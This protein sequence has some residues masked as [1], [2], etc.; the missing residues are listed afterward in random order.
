MTTTHVMKGVNPF[1]GYAQTKQAGNLKDG[2]TGSFTDAFSKATG[3]QNMTLQKDAG[4]KPGTQAKPSNTET[5]NLE[6]NKA[7]KIKDNG[8]EN[9]SKGKDVQTV[10]KVQ[11]EAEKAGQELAGEVAEEL[12]VTEEEVL[13]AMELLGLTFSDLLNPD[14]MTQL[15]LTV[16]EAD[17]LTLMT[18]GGLYD[19]LQ[20]LLGAVTQ[21]LTQIGEETGLSPEELAAIL[22]QL[23]Q[24]PQ[25]PVQT[26][27]YAQTDRKGQED[28]ILPDGQ[29]DY[30]VT[31]ERDG[32][33]MKV[34]VEVDGNAKTETA[35]V[36]NTKA[37]VPK[38]ETVEPAKKDQGA[39]QEQSPQSSD[40]HSNV[41][42]D[43]LLNRDNGAVQTDAAFETAM[44]GRTVDTQE[45]MNQIMNYMRV[46]VKADMTQMQLQLHP[47]SLG[48][49]NIN[50]ASKAGVIT[51]QFT[52]QN[53]AVKSV[54]ESQIVQLR[55][56]FEEQGIKVEAVEVTVESHAFERN[57]NGENSNRQAAQEGKKRGTRKLNLNALEEEGAAMEED[58]RLAVEMMR[59]GGNTVDFTA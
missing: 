1:A 13:K 34:S 40:T 23:E 21:Q 33:V 18:D 43:N 8:T 24:Q 47:A 57:L 16:K 38:E 31:V 36:T 46:Q 32:E 11:A 27:G 51:A 14:Q 50:I 37:E 19:S 59:A 52:A 56:N 54:L 5:K 10:D 7:V 9:V 6:D 22:E 44:A 17:M 55:N 29:E 26:D 48:T 12:G 3:Q 15:V 39:K 58:D 20:N 42:L 4:V 35:E 2:L 28:A 53:E 41:L 30:T 25:E 45:I 49:V